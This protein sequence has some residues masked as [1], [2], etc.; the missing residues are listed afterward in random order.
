MVSECALGT[1]Q[2][3]VYENNT[4]SITLKYNGQKINS[5]PILCV[6]LC[7]VHFSSSSSYFIN[8]TVSVVMILF[9]CFSSYRNQTFRWESLNQAKHIT[10]IESESE[11][12]TNQK[13][14][15]KTKKNNITM[16]NERWWLSVCTLVMCYNRSRQNKLTFNTIVQ[17]QPS[18]ALN[19]VLFF[20]LVGF[21]HLECCF[22]LAFL[23]RSL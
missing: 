16:S 14:K 21:F 6:Y 23:A 5:M 13:L 12:K 10:T 2:M 19:S 8:N 15:T 18:Y 22:L 4:N 7:S 11:R 1:K 17:H 3:R 9:P 20:I